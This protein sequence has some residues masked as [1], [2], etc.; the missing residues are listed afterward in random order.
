[1]MLVLLALLLDNLLPDNSYDLAIIPAIIGAVGALGSSQPNLLYPFFK[2][3]PNT[4]DNIFA[5]KA[6]STWTTDQLLVNCNIDCKVV[7][8]LSQDGVPY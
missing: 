1:M 2:V 7:R 5:V 4:L 3:N 8:P 6:D